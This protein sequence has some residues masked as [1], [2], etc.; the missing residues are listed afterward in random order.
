MQLILSQIYTTITKKKVILTPM[1]I[2]LQ[3]VKNSG[4]SERK[5]VQEQFCKYI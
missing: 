3:I 5:A 2:P 4:S 1:D